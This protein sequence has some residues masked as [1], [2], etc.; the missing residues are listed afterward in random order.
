[1]HCGGVTG[2][3]RIAAMS[4]AFN[5]DLSTHGAP[6]VHAH[7]GVVAPR[8]RHCEWPQDHLRIEQKLFDGAPVARG[9]FVAPDDTRPGL[10]LVLK[11]HDVA[12]YEAA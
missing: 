1:V 5:V 3:L 2:F 12:R 4:D 7:L 11:Q 10:G 6:A 8:V 9:G